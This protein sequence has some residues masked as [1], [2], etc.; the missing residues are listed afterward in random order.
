MPSATVRC[1]RVADG[2]MA[3]IFAG[4]TGEGRN[5]QVKR[6]IDRHFIVEELKLTCPTALN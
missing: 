4:T 5:R 3:R 1:D 2:Y 6:K